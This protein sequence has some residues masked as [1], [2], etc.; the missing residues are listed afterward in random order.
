[1]SDIEKE[2]SSEKGL[3]FEIT[4]P[5]DKITNRFFSVEARFNWKEVLIGPEQ[6]TVRFEFSVE[7][8]EGRIVSASYGLNENTGEINLKQNESCHITLMLPEGIS[9]SKTTIYLIDA[10]TSKELSK[11]ENLKIALSI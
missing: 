4:Y 3:K 1:V 5:K 10:N 8:K 7:G 11:I 9:Q 6:Y 2:K